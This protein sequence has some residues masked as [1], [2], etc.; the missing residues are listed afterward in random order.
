MYDHDPYLFA[1]CDSD[2]NIYDVHIS[3][4]LRSTG[5]WE[6]IE[7]N[8][9]LPHSH[10]LLIWRRDQEK[11][12]QKNAS[13][14][15]KYIK[16]DLEEFVIEGRDE[17]NAGQVH[18]RRKI[19]RDHD[20][21]V[22]AWDKMSLPKQFS[23]WAEFLNVSYMMVDGESSVIAKPNSRHDRKLAIYEGQMFTE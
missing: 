12:T 22:L 5:T 4:D 17:G 3:D 14:L 7:H 13:V 21:L 11:I 1:L 23:T 16:D 9:S 19:T 2:G 6:Y 8:Y 20:Y 15:F 10:Y 18:I